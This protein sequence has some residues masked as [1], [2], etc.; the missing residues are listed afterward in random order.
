MPDVLLRAELVDLLDGRRAFDRA[1]VEGAWNQV[2]RGTYVPACAAPDLR[3]RAAA[4]GR[5]LPEH[6]VVAD[7]CLLWLLGIDVLLPGPPVLE[8]VVPRGAVVPCRQDVHARTAELAAH[9]AFR[10]QPLGVRC[11]RPVRAVTDLLRLLPP[12]EAVVVADAVQHA[13]VCDADALRRELGAATG[14]RYVVRARRALELSDPRAES[15]PESRLRFALHGAGLAPVPQYVVLDVHGRFVARVDLALPDQRI[16]LE[17]DG[18]AVHDRA[19]AFLA[20]RRRQNALV[21]AGWTVLR[22]T[23]ADL[24]RGA[25]PAVAQVL[26]AGARR[27]LTRRS[28]ISCTPWRARRA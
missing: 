14:L 7:R 20:D 18:K 1:L 4:A 24:R 9:D 13:G 16:A 25:A 6:A 15:P 23:A 11:L 12:V 5:L 28:W 8:V 17:H 22:F 3:L 27:R 21:A 10:L 26:G 2:L 19:D